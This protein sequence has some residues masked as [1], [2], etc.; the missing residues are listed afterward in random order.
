MKILVTGSEGTLGKPLVT[1]LRVQGHDVWT[2]DMQH[3]ANLQ[4]IRA[5]IGDWR[6]LERAVN[7]ANPDM[8]YHLAAEFGRKNGEDYYERLWRTNVIGTRNMLEAQRRL[9]FK[10]IFASS[11]EVYGDLPVDVLYEGLVPENTVE[12]ENDY[13]LSKWVNEEQIHRFARQERTETM[14]LR[15]FNAY[16]P[17]EHYHAY[18]SVVCLFCWN[19]LHGE[20]IQVYE[21][22]HRVFMFIDDF[23]PTLARAATQF[24]PGETVN[25]GGTDYRS[26]EELADIVLRETGADPSLVHKVGLEQHNTRNKK[27]DITK[28]RQLLGHSPEVEL[29][30]GVGMTV[31]WMRDLIGVP[32]F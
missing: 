13:A 26:V 14:V 32:A 9:R 21:G 30:V 31:G 23:I 4:H 29:E 25:I 6:E 19:L 15:F 18:R 20:R 2:L 11:S 1:H 10:M 27:P 8:V 16:G 24:V 5:D 7:L 3:G 17:G 28:A 12:H 22:Y